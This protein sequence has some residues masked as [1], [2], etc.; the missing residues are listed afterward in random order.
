MAPVHM[1]AP[2]HCTQGQARHGAVST[3]KGL[4]SPERQAYTRASCCTHP[5]CRRCRPVQPHVCTTLHAWGPC[6]PVRHA[7]I[8]QL[9]PQHWVQ[10]RPAHRLR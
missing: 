6:A 10:H 8:A 3:T 5:R 4:P 9:P 1:H 7:G 2:V